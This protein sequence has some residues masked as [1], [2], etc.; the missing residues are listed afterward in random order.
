MGINFLWQLSLYSP[1]TKIVHKFVYL[2]FFHLLSHF[3]IYQL[4]FSPSFCCNRVSSAYLIKP[5]LIFTA[6][7]LT[8]Y[9]LRL[10]CL[11][12]II[13]VIVSN[14]ARN[15]LDDRSRIS[16][17]SLIPSACAL[18]KGKKGK[19]EHP[20]YP[21]KLLLKSSLC[22]VLLELLEVIE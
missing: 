18:R 22:F 1:D 16:C 13:V 15:T 21:V 8:N 20:K 19:C 6:S 11:L 2:I 12:F 5:W 10:V 7:Q 9:N 3:L 4:S 14:F 17:F